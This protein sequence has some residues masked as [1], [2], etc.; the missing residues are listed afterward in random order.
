MVQFDLNSWT[1][2]LYQDGLLKGDD[3]PFYNNVDNLYYVFIQPDYNKGFPYCNYVLDNMELKKSVAVIPDG[4]ETW[5]VGEYLTLSWEGAGFDEA[6]ACKENEHPT[7]C[8]YRAMFESL[9]GGLTDFVFNNFLLALMFFI[10]V[11]VAIL[12]KR[13]K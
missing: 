8:F 11:L 7:I 3:V 9:M 4:N 2:D 13:H 12:L 5:M 10:I 6:K 1:Y